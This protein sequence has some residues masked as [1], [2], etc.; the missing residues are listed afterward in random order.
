MRV[1]L[2]FDAFGYEDRGNYWWATRDL[3]FSTGIIQSSGRHMRLSIGDVHTGFHRG[4]D[5]EL[6]Y[7]AL[8]L[9]NEWR[10]L[11]DERLKHAF[12][13][14]V[15]FAMVFENMPRALAEEL[16]QALSSEPG[17]LGA[18]E[19]NFEFGP[20]LARYRIPEKYR[21]SGTY[22][23]GFLSMGMEDDK[24][25]YDLDEMR[26]LGYADVGWEDRGAHQTIFDD[27]DTP[28]HFARVAAVR[29]S[30]SRS[31]RGGEDAAFELVMVL[32]DLNPKLFNALGAAVER[33]VGAETE[34]DVAQAALSGRRYMEQLADVL[35]P[36]QDG[37]RKGRSI[38]KAAYRNR[39]WAFVE[40]NT[41][42]D[43]AR[44]DAL[45]KEVD[46]LVEELNGGLH[47]EKPQ[48]RILEA[49]A[50]AAQLT[51]ELLAL[52]PEEARKPYYAFNDRIVAFLR[53][54]V[55]RREESGSAKD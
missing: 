22:C 55:S 5:P 9:E 35:F 11:H 19:V 28:R 15:V 8:F 29:Q 34:E 12:M 47:G 31:L 7:R 3:V 1:A 40:D 4:D 41:A 16:H 25:E 45:G 48:E 42:E 27:F 24:D 33:L 38:G 44:R 51:A 26:R 46:R 54:S 39:L 21:L 17:Y 2:L 32:G 6:I 18:V 53:E 14:S 20:H 30:I 36:A 10:Q 49:F 52:N 50:D 13:R 37:K 43:E 23:R